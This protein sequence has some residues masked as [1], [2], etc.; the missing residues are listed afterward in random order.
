MKYIVLQSFSSTEYGI[1][2]RLTCDM[3]QCLSPWRPNYRVQITCDERRWNAMFSC[4]IFSLRDQLG[5]YQYSLQYRYSAI[6]SSDDTENLRNVT[7]KVF[8]NNCVTNGA[9]LW[10][11]SSVNSDGHDFNSSGWW[12][13]TMGV[14]TGN[15]ASEISVDRLNSVV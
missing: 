5:S 11:E 7:S 10:C 2:V 12:K 4:Q 6:N 14:H 9:T 1:I 3:R 13:N 8:R 15:L